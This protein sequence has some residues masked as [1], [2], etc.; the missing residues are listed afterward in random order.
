MIRAIYGLPAKCVGYKS[1]LLAERRNNTHTLLVTQQL[2][3]VFLQSGSS[4]S[5]S[6]VFLYKVY[7]CTLYEEVRIIFCVNLLLPS[8]CGARFCHLY[9]LACSYSPPPCSL[10]A[11]AQAHGRPTV[12]LL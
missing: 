3:V 5:V 1:L 6:N 4:V 7:S 8:F 2:W 9:Y 11:L 12:S 10:Q